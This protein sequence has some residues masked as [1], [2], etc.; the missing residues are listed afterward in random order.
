MQ[1]GQP[2]QKK[3][4]TSILPLPGSGSGVPRRR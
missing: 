3:S 1:C 4:I 2:Y